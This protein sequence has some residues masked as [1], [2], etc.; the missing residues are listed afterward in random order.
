MTMIK[1]IIFDVGGVID[2]FDESQYIDYICKK[3]K[4]DPMKFRRELIPKLDK[5]EVDKMKLAKLKTDLSKKFGVSV[6]A[7]EWGEAFLKLNSVNNDV[8]GL[9]GRLSKHYKIAVLTN[10]SRSRHMVK[11]E[12]YLEKV[13]YDA[14]FA[15]CY[16]KMHKPDSRIYRFVLKKM[17]A[18]PGETLFIDNLKRNTDGAK[19]LGINVIQ[20]I[21]YGDLVNRLRKLGINC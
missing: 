7:L 1:L 5:M 18:N 12:H 20:F 13:K 9:I 3:L 2:T 4:I 19:R 17:N 6:K 8:V 10:V 16:L 11:M 21:G 14:I 15:S